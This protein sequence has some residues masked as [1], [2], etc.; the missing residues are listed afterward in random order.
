MDKNPKKQLGKCS[1]ILG[2][3]KKENG[4]IIFE[5]RE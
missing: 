5:L 4:L 2:G 3:R 1:K